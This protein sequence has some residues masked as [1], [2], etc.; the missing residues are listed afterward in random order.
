MRHEGHRPGF[1]HRQGRRSGLCRNRCD[2]RL[3]ERQGLIGPND[4][5]HEERQGDEVDRARYI[6]A[7]I[8][9]IRQWLKDDDEDED[10]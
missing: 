5:A 3:G 7:A 10:A 4:E 1:Q 8:D 2:D 9:E 6:A